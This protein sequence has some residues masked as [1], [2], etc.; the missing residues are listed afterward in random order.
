MILWFAPRGGGGL[1]RPPVRIVFLFPSLW[2][3]PGA[4]SLMIKAER[5]KQ[6]AGLVFVCFLP[7]FY[8]LS[9]LLLS[10]LSGSF[11]ASCLL[12]SA[13]SDMSCVGCVSPSSSPFLLCFVAAFYFPLFFLYLYLSTDFFVSLFTIP[14]HPLALPFT[15][16]LK[17]NFSPFFSSFIAF[18]LSL[19]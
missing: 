2:A 10:C 19:S 15:L 12:P 7:V 4:C 6:R 16:S 14:C 3:L 9:C 8:L 1:R 17:L 11:L 18:S 13:L 5:D